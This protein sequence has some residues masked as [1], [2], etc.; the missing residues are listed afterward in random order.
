[1][2]AARLP[3]PARSGL[4]VSSWRIKSSLFLDEVGDMPLELQPKLLRV[5]QEQEFERL[6]SNKLIQTDVRLIAATNRDLK[7][8]GRRSRIP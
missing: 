2:S 4:A 5:L 3:A 7:K 8:N 6:G 1:M